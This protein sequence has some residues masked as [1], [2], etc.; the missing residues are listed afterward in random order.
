MILTDGVRGSR[1]AQK[2]RYPHLLALLV[3]LK[4]ALVQAGSG[5]TKAGNFYENDRN[6]KKAER[7]TRYVPYPW[8][9]YGDAALP[10][11]TSSKERATGRATA[12]PSAVPPAQA[13]TTL[14]RHQQ[15]PIT[16]A[17]GVQRLCFESTATD[18]RF[19]AQDRNS[20]F[21]PALRKHRCRPQ[22]AQQK[23]FALTSRT[24]SPHF[25]LGA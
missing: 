16:C 7:D 22:H 3:L 18:G 17:R 12:A 8:M 24:V 14:Y 6:Q 20:D 10:R 5:A 23:T 19:G 13:P 1:S 9:V 25:Q 21:A 2:N 11:R 15:R 4:V